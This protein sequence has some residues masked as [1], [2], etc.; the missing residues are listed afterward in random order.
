MI[1][2]NDLK[3]ATVYQLVGMV[4]DDWED[5]DRDLYR[6]LSELNVDDIKDSTHWAALNIF[7]GHADK[8]NTDDSEAIKQELRARMQ[9]YEAH[10]N[11]TG[12]SRVGS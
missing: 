5:M 7:L 1:K 2:K 11:Y 9:E 6:L 10:L 4:K 12:G 3:F 8:W